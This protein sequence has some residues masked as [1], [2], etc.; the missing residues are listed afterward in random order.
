[1]RPEARTDARDSTAEFTQL[2]ARLAALEAELA[3]RQATRLGMMVRVLRSA[4][5][6]PIRRKALFGDLARVVID[7]QPPSGSLSRTHWP[8]SSAIPG[9]GVPHGPVARADLK[10]G[11]ILDPFSE[12][13][14]RYEWNHV[15]FG[16]DD[17]RESLEADLPALL[18]V[19]SAWNGNGGRWRLHMTQASGPSAELRALVEWCRERDIPT[20]FWNKEDPPNYDRFIATAKLFDDVFTVDA[21]RLDAYRRDLGHDQ[22]GLLPFAAQPRIHNPIRRGAGRVYDVAFAGSYFKH[23]HPDR[24]E[25]MQYILGPARDFGLHIYSRLKSEDRRYQFPRGYTPYIVDSL[26]YEQMLAAYT[27]Y[28]VFLNVNSV[29]ESVT[30]CSRRLF[31]LSAAQTPVL[32]GPAASI[33][34]FFG[35]AVTVATDAAETRRH[36]AALLHQDEYRDRLALRAHRRVFEEHLYRHRVDSVLAAVGIESTTS[37]PQ[38]TVVVPTHRPGQL[39]NVLAFVGRQKHPALQLVLVTHGF[40]PEGDLAAKAM[41]VGVDDLIV[42]NADSA[43]TLGACMN[44]GLDAADGEYVAKMDDDNWYGAHYLSDL[45]Y[46]FQYTDATAVGKWAHFVHHE[47]SQATLLRFPNS[48]HRYVNL[49]QG[50]TIL[51]ERSAARDLRFEDLPR[52]V[53]TTFLDKLRAA[54]GKLYSADRFNFVSMRRADPG[55]H[56]WQITQESMLG[57]QAKLL[58]YGEPYTHADV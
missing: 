47:G 32:S 7:R 48:E 6:D 4:V 58:F 28:R 20:V 57:G 29:T 3:M 36:L 40:E 33:E 51:V 43:L 18:F 46:A 34:P 17:W 15:M 23:K 56:T 42:L 30:M 55:E 10:V 13:A 16:P 44:L 31:E 27:S 54:G 24:R 41:E 19:E 9:L 22:I 52:R 26:P 53:D 45:A 35:K 49:V 37:T 2:R 38:I 14:L 25:Q 8:S 50:G 1:M 11:V 21:D 12:L 5:G 39:E